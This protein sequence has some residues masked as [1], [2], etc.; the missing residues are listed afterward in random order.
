MSPDKGLLRD[1]FGW[2]LDGYDGEASV[3]GGMARRL[4]AEIRRHGGGHYDSVLEIGCGSGLLSRELTR[5][6]EIREV[7]ANDLVEECGARVEG[8]VKRLPGVAFSFRPGDIEK[9]DLPPETFDLVASNAVF[10]WL[11]DLAGLLERLAPVLRAGGLLAFTTF[12]PDNVREVAAVGGRGLGYRSIDEVAALVKRRYRI[13]HRRE[14]RET[15]RFPSP[16]KVLEHLRR[17]GAN[18]LERTGWTRGV[19]RAFEGEYRGRFGSGDEVTLTYHPMFF[20]AR[21]KD[22]E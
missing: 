16:R 14:S 21:R 4:V 15:L 7:V 17:T 5:R 13:L 22:E 2:S 19:L 6:L 11:D 1:R 10:H 18:S 9:I 20:V 12:G 3:Q 8:I